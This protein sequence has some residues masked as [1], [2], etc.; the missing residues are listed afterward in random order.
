[1]CCR[2]SGERG[3]RAIPAWRGALGTMLKLTGAG[4]VVRLAT[5]GWKT[6]LA[7]DAGWPARFDDGAGHA[8]GRRPASQAWPPTAA[9]RQD[10]FDAAALP[11]EARLYVTALGPTKPS[12]MA[13]RRRSL[14]PEHRLP[15]R[16]LYQTYDVT[17]RLGRACKASMF[18]TAGTPA[19]SRPAAAAP[20]AR[21]RAASWPS[22]DD[23][24]RCGSRQVVA[25]ARLARGDP[26]AQSEI[27]N[28]ES[29][30]ARRETRLSE[31]RRR[32]RLDVAAA[33]PPS[34]SHHPAGP[35][36]RSPR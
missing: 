36:I 13:H 4:S 20:T 7:D 12:S 9:M 2:R 10:C 31:P 15:K 19:W 14:A 33:E 17:A 21:R 3:R 16:V 1:M 25:A 28:G 26:R 24:R 11:V 23:L 30:D 6:S 35:P 22:W 34:S 8:A 5:R 32:G 18:A 27:Y 29:W